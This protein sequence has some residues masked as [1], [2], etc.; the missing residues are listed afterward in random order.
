MN[1]SMVFIYEKN[2]LPTRRT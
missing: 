1:L 2:K